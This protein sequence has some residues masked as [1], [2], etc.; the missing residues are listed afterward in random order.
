M[1][2]VARLTALLFAAIIASAQA[3]AP[4]AGDTAAR[5]RA[6]HLAEQLRCLV[7]QNQTI[8]DSNAALAVDLRREIREQIGQG[9][10]DPEIVDFMVQ[11]YGDFVLYNPPLKATTLLLWLG[12]LLL[13]VVG[14]AALIRNV[15][16]RRR[17][18]APAP[19][20]AEEARR[21]A[22]LLDAPGPGE[23]K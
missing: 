6:V 5:E 2:L 1:K 21:A 18:A 12:P 7:C 22:Q 13:L 20:S 23:R 9:R 8:A 10:S 3:Q 4:T 17:L 15:R 14:M 16:Q 19:L 11:R